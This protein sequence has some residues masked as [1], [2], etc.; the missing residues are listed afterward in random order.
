M[1]KIT[2]MSNFESGLGTDKSDVGETLAQLMDTACGGGIASNYN[3]LRAPILET[4]DDG[5]INLK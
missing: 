4:R 1:P 5:R 3:N 2:I